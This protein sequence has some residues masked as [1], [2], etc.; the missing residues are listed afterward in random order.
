MKRQERVIAYRGPKNLAQL[1]K[2]R[3]QLLH[4]YVKRIVMQSWYDINRFLGRPFSSLSKPASSG[5]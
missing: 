4:A 2:P 1:M 5:I 3:V